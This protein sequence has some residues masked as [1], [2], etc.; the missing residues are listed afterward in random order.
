VCWCFASLADIW[1]SGPAVNH[2]RLRGSSTAAAVI[3]VTVTVASNMARI[4]GLI[5]PALRT[6]SEQ[7]VMPANSRRLRTSR[8]IENSGDIEYE[9][10]IRHQIENKRYERN[11]EF[12]SFQALHSAGIA[13]RQNTSTR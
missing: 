9:T 7:T 2:V 10:V 4:R 5:S 3:T 11:P 13:G 12:G 1:M 6:A 8:A